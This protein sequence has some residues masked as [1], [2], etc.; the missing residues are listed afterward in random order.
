MTSLTD[1]RRYITVMNDPLLVLHPQLPAAI[2]G[3]IHCSKLRAAVYC[4]RWI[5]ESPP[6]VE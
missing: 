2:W 1:A 4:R 6:P 5:Y 3:E